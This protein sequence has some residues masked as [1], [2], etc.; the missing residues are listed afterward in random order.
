M[1]LVMLAFVRCAVTLIE[2]PA[3]TLMG[4]FPYLV[5]AARTIS[6]W[7]PWLEVR[8]SGPKYFAPA[9]CMHAIKISGLYIAINIFLEFTTE[10]DG[11]FWPP[12]PEAYG[13]FWICAR[14]SKLISCISLVFCRC[15][16][17]SHD[18]AIYLLR[19]SHFESIAL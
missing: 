2:Q 1:L 11:C 15:K 19:L 12:Q 16:V 5:W 13:G 3:N 9:S 8:L 6:L 17:L 18:D 14:H 7:W 4:Y 10:S